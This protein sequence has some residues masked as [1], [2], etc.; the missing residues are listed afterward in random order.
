MK[1]K[2]AAVKKIGDLIVMMSTTLLDSFLSD[3]ADKRLAKEYSQEL[4]KMLQEAMNQK[5]LVVL[6]VATDK[7][8]KVEF[9]SG[10]IV[11]KHIGNEQIVLKLQS[12]T[13]QMRILSTT[14][15]QK[16]SVFPSPQRTVG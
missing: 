15:I 9:I 1:K 12:D 11:G 4:Q 14:D 16:V 5:Q 7:A 3:D 10:W 2:S 6:Q 13:K 8:E